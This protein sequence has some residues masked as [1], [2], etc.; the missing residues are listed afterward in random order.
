MENTSIATHKVS[1]YGVR[2][3]YN[4][5]TGE[6]WGVNTICDHLALAAAYL[7]N[8]FCWACPGAGEDGFPFV[9]LEEY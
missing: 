8:F 1:F 9:I 2:C 6:F 7:H 5:D 4:I 3:Y